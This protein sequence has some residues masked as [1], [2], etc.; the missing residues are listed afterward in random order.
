M[1]ERISFKNLIRKGKLIKIVGAHNG[2]TAKLVQE[3]GFDGVWA[4]GFEI[5]TSHAVPDANILTMSDLLYATESMVNATSIPIMV[6]CDTGFGNSNNVMHMI[7]KFESAGVSA[8]CIEDKQFPKVNSFI[9]GRQELAPI[10]EFVGKIMAAKNSQTTD[11]FMVFARVEALIAGWG[12]DE[13]LKRAQA[14]IEAGADGIFIHSKSKTPD[15]IINFCKAW[16]KRAP[17]VLCPTMYDLSEKQMRDLGASVVIYAN[18]GMRAGIKCIKQALKY[19][20]DNGI[21]GIDSK[22]V[23]M[24]EVF[25]LQGMHIM[26]SNERKYLKTNTGS[27]KAIIPAAGPKMDNSLKPL[28]EDR[29][30]GMLDINGKSLL[31]R[32]VETL[33]TAGVQDISVVVGYKSSNVKL[34]GAG[35]IENKSYRS[36][37]IMYSIMKGIDKIADKNL[38]LYSDILVDQYLLQRL[39]KKD[40]DIILVVDST[41]KKTHIRN[42]QL[43]LVVAKTAHLDNLRTMDLNR[44]NPIRNI[45]NDISEKEAHFEF[46]G[47]A[48]LS[49][50][51]MKALVDEYKKSR[52]MQTA[53][54]AELIGHLI[55][56]K[57][58][59]LAYE[60]TSGWMEIHN[61][62][63][64]KKACAIFSSSVS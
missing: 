33:N 20:K 53:S 5:A 11:D 43:E 9:P 64:Y 57:Y 28:L 21:S 27:I 10:A 15:E 8:V 41:Y 19:I 18:H 35:I 54:F 34:E 44:K 56:K 45:G 61:F 59:V 38:I 3:A 30:V 31:Q 4:S 36:K 60:V 39:L 1:R 55:N 12:Q 14:Y 16:K 63:D 22:I 37:G 62:D 23:S 13:A 51:G 40:D 17:L 52:P 42:K 47:L 29:P 49:K 32:N 50:K 58:E 26:K 2:L 6:D 46:I 24:D 48:M 25:R 7:R